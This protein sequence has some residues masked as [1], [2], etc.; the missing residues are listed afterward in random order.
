MDRRVIGGIAGIASPVVFTAFVATSGAIVPH[1]DHVS[2]HVSELARQ[3]GPH[4][5]VMRLGLVLVGVF[6]VLL[7]RGLARSAQSRAGRIG[8]WLVAMLGVASAGVGLLP[9]QP[10]GAEA[11]T[12]GRAH[13]GAAAVAFTLDV[14]TPLVFA[15][16]FRNAAGGRVLRWLSLGSGALAALLLIPVI[17]GLFPAQKGLVQRLFLAVPFAWTGLMGAWLLMTPVEG[18]R[19]TG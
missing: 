4:A 15:A 14:V 1:Y 5:W 13:L 17:L 12:L 6:D 10:A 7:A 2:Q 3:G 19:T 8:S 9:L 16:H 18:R 11:N